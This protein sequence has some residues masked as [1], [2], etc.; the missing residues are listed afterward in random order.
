MNHVGRGNVELFGL[1]L[2][3]C[4]VVAIEVDM[5]GTPFFDLKVYDFLG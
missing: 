3:E 1:S 4:T 5:M 2:L